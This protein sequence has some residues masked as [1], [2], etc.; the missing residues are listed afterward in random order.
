MFN[1]SRIPIRRE[2]G[3]PTLQDIIPNPAAKIAP[4]MHAGLDPGAEA[5]GNRPHPIAAAMVSGT[6][7]M[8]QSTPQAR[9]RFARA[10]SLTVKAA[11]A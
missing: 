7:V 11:S 6:S 2:S 8:R 1:S 9:S 4:A 3:E 5:A 10:G